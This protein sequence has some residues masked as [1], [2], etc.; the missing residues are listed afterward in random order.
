MEKR[1]GLHR[2]YEDFLR[3]SEE[4][5]EFLTNAIF[6][7]RRSGELSTGGLPS[8]TRAKT[9]RGWSRRSGD[10]ERKGPETGTYSQKPDPGSA[11]HSAS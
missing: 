3:A 4:D 2:Q 5:H 9:S 11:H 10:E 6:D 7:P 1:I 8:W